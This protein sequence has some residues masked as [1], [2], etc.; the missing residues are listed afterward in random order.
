[1]RALPIHFFGNFSYRTDCLA[2]I[3]VG[4]IV[5][6]QH[7]AKSQTAEISASGI[8]MDSMVTR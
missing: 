5:K 7:T 3:A 1:M 2:I 6:P 4:C 8:A